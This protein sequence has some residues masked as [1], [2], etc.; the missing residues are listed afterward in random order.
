MSIPKSRGKST[1]SL[2]GSTNGA[3][4]CWFTREVAFVRCAVDF[5]SEGPQYVV[6]RVPFIR[7]L[8]SLHSRGPCERL[9][10]PPKLR[11]LRS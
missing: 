10:V 8:D 7:R 4:S 3:A 11:D 5:K 6:L 2:D 9:Q 1:P